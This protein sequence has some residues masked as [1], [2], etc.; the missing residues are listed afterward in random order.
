MKK[1]KCNNCN[2]EIRESNYERNSRKE[3]EREDKQRNKRK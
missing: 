3:V 2:E 1:R